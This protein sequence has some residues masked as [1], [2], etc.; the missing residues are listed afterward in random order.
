MRAELEHAQREIQ[1]LEAKKGRSDRSIADSGTRVTEL[2]QQLA[3]FTS[4]AEAAM[5]DAKEKDATVLEMQQ[6]Q[7]ANTK[8]VED[9]H[10]TELG[11]KAVEAVGLRAQI[12]SLEEQ[13]ATLERRHL[14]DQASLRNQTQ[15]LG[16]AEEYN[17]T[18]LQKIADHA[19]AVLDAQNKLHAAHTDKQ[20]GETDKDRLAH[21]LSAATQEAGTLQA[22]LTTAREQLNT[23]TNQLQQA[24]GAKQSAVRDRDAIEKILRDFEPKYQSLEAAR[25]EQGIRQTVCCTPAL[26]GLVWC[27]LRFLSEGLTNRSFGLCVAGNGGRYRRYERIQARVAADSLRAAGQVPSFRS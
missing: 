16:I 13:V 21:Q 5:R 2:E 9:E 11:T 27:A 15:K 1:H 8:S 10:A 20:A 25:D 6:Q 17:L 22:S 18:L 24:L 4:R 26:S 7:A 19:A 3:L 23:T 14:A 12:D